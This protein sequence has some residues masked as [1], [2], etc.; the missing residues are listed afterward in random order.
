MAWQDLLQADKPII[1]APWLGTGWVWLGD[2]SWE[3]QGRKPDEYCWGKFECDHRKARFLETT[4]PDFSV[5][6]H[7]VVGY[8]V[9]DRIVPDD[10]PAFF[11]LSGL[12]ERS[13]RVCLIDPGLD[14][15]ARIKAGRPTPLSPLVFCNQEMPLGPEQDVLRAYQDRSESVRKIPG[16]IPGLDA[17]F[18]LESFQ[19]QEAERRR[20]EIEEQRKAELE[21]LERE[22]RIKEVAKRL[23]DGAGRRE[24][25]KVDFAQAARAA[26]AVG[27]AEYLDHK[28]SNNPSEIRVWFRLHER[29]FECTCEFRT[30][31]I[32]SSG[33]CLTDEDTGYSADAELTLESLPSVIM[34]AD[35]THRLV[36]LRHAE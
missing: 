11:D 24:M 20:A 8:L 19:R 17:A 30:L 15:F 25:A 12:R 23:G 9:G 13:M 26:L 28:R 7:H 21:R 4:D 3:I 22:E 32:I 2:R 14:R 27:G 10:R 5:L 6:C 16:V 35:R 1:T 29:R 31:R 34:E 33:I 18:R 36:V